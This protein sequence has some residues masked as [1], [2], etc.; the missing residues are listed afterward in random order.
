MDSSISAHGGG[1]FTECVEGIREHAEVGVA[2]GG[3]GATEIFAKFWE[4]AHE[5]Y[6]ITKQVKTKGRE[7]YEIVKYWWEVTYDLEIMDCRS[8]QPTRMAWG[9]VRTAR[10][11]R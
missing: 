1:E 7:F 2:D 8:I 3:F 6:A 10:R 5:T 4:V 9:R 11:M